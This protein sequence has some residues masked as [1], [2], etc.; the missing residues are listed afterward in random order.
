MMFQNCVRLA[1]RRDR[2]V[3]MLSVSE[4]RFPFTVI[5]KLRMRWSPCLGICLLLQA[6]GSVS[7]APTWLKRRRDRKAVDRALR[8]TDDEGCE[9]AVDKLLCTNDW[10]ALFKARCGARQATGPRFTPPNCPH[11]AQTGCSSRAS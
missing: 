8:L 5:A 1:T 11:R 9:A 6:M 10:F 3:R 2:P 4:L 7:G